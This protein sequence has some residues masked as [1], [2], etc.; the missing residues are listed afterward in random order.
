MKRHRAHVAHK[1]P[2]RIRVKIPSARNDPEALRHF[3]EMFSGFPNVASVTSRLETGSVLV[4]YDALREDE[5]AEQFAAWH[6]EHAR[7]SGAARPGD[8]VGEVMNEISAE[9]NFL[10]KHSKAASATVELFRTL[11]HQIKI[12]TGNAIDLQIVLVAGLAVVTFVEIG[13][14]ATTPMWVTLALFGVNHFIE[15]RHPALPPGR[16]A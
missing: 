8:E 14:E 13:A 5:F 10:A 11:D 12:A 15:I 2:G 9:A 3:H 16:P 4:Q 6:A 7:E 1:L